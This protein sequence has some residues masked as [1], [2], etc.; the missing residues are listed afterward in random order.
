M[1]AKAFGYRTIDIHSGGKDLCFPHH[2]N[3]I[4]QA[5]A[6][7]H[8]ET[9]EKNNN[10]VSCFLH[11]GHLALSSTN[12]DMQQ[13]KMSKS[14]GNTVTIRQ[15]LRDHCASPRQLRLLFAL[16]PWEKNMTYVKQD[17]EEKE[18]TRSSH[19]SL[20][21]AKAKER[22][23]I[24]FFQNV[25]AASSSSLR[26]DTVETPSEEEKDAA[27]RARLS[28]CHSIVDDAFRSNI[29]VPRALQAMVFGP[30]SLARGVNAY[31]SY[32]VNTIDT[33]PCPRLLRRCGDFVADMLELMGIDV[34]D[35]YLRRGLVNETTNENGKVDTLLIDELASFR[36]DVRAC[37]LSVGKQHRDA[38]AM[39]TCSK[40]LLALCDRVRDGGRLVELGIHL[41]D[42]RNAR[43]WSW[44]KDAS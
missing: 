38:T 7:R 16:T 9:G 8:T 21:V 44:K 14:L 37:A 5:T 32:C 25:V 23:L 22:D 19:S 43:G 3:E 4:A 33:Q 17:G 31:I 40:Q 2:E 30:D 20:V 13:E 11:V 35:I 36:A 27:L 10:W 1:A 28:E 41:E 29:D 39:I 12:G 6:F 42:T 15:S 34:N 24:R 18:T 26:R